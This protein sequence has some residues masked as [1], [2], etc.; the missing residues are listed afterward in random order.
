MSRR[1]AGPRL[2]NMTAVDDP[3]E[4]TRCGLLPTQAKMKSAGFQN[5]SAAARG[6][7][8][9]LETVSE[10]FRITARSAYWCKEVPLTNS[11]AASETSHVRSDPWGLGLELPPSRGGLGGAIARSP[12]P[13]GAR[14]S[15][16]T[17]VFQALALRS[18]NSFIKGHM[19]G[20]QLHIYTPQETDTPC[21]WSS[22]PRRTPG[23]RAGIKLHKERPE[24]TVRGGRGDHRPSGSRRCGEKPKRPGPAWNQGPKQA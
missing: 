8:K 22:G 13:N 5:S 10:S 7:P 24:K 6:D 19:P 9:R 11:S 23:S 15:G 4:R 16:L 1:S 18:W 20:M 3:R 2:Y 17:S 14:I 21:G 12:P